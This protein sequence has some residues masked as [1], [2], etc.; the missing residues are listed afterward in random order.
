MGISVAIGSAALGAYGADRQ[1]KAA[2]Q[3]AEEQANAIRVQ[4]EQTRQAAEAAANA[5][6]AQKAS[7]Q[8]QAA[9]RA[10]QEADAQAAALAGQKDQT[11]TVDVGPK[12]SDE[13]VIRKRAK[14]M[15]PTDPSTSIR[16]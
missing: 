14:F 10:K 8:V 16:I 15:L 5:A 4:A 1:A 3:A 13:P 9:A 12:A 11:V 2:K 6:T 7:E